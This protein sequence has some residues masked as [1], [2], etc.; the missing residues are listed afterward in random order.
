VLGVYSQ[1]LSGNPQKNKVVAYLAV[2]NAKGS[3]GKGRMP[4]RYSSKMS[5]KRILNF[6]LLNNLAFFARFVFLDVVWLF[7]QKVSGNPAAANILT[8][9]GKSCSTASEVK[10]RFARVGPNFEARTRPES[11]IYFWNPI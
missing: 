2:H 1:T 4:Q 7:S 8:S 6:M 5:Y 3:S 11:D 10:D 9:E